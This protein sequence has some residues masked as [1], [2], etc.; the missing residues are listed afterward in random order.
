[1]MGRRTWPHPVVHDPCVCPATLRSAESLRRQADVAAA[2]AKATQ[3][4]SL[5]A[6]SSQT[7]P[8][9]ASRT[10]QPAPARGDV[11]PTGARTPVAGR[12]PRHLTPPRHISPPCSI[13]G[14]SSP[15]RHLTPSRL[16]GDSLRS[17]SP[18]LSPTICARE[19]F[20]KAV[21]KHQE[22]KPLTQSRGQ[23]P[24]NDYLAEAHE[25]RVSRPRTQSP[26]PT[27]LAPIRGPPA[28]PVTLSQ[29]TMAAHR[30]SWASAPC[31]YTPP[32]CPYTPPAT[33]PYTPPFPSSVKTSL[34]ELQSKSVA[35]ATKPVS[36]VFAKS[37]S[38]NCI[39]TKLTVTT[40]TVQPN[41]A[42]HRRAW[43]GQDCVVTLAAGD[44][45]EISRTESRQTVSVKLRPST[46]LS[47]VRRPRT[48]AARANQD[49]GNAS[50]TT[51]WG[52]SPGT[53]RSPSPKFIRSARGASSPSSPR[54][55][56]PYPASPRLTTPAPHHSP[57]TWRPKVVEPSKVPVEADQE[58]ACPRPSPAPAILDAEEGDPMP[59]GRQ[60]V[61][62]AAASMPV[63]PEEQSLEFTFDVTFLLPSGEEGKEF[64]EHLLAACS[65]LAPAHVTTTNV[66]AVDKLSE[67]ISALIPCAG[68]GT[69]L[70][71]LR[72]LG[73]ADAL[74]HV[75]LRARC[76]GT[77][78]GASLPQG[79]LPETTDKTS[80]RSTAL[81]YV[82]HSF[83]SME[84]KERQLGPICAVEASYKA[85]AGGFMPLRLVVALHDA[86]APANESD[87]PG[88]LGE[89]VLKE[90]RARR[91]LE[92]PGLAVNRG[93]TAGHRALVQHIAECLA[94]HFDTAHSEK[95]KKS[96]AE[97][98]ESFAEEATAT[99]QS[100]TSSSPRSA[101]G[102]SVLSNLP[103]GGLRRSSHRRDEECGEA[104]DASEDRR[105]GSAAGLL[106][107]V[108]VA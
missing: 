6:G 27:P 39:T 91:V 13:S 97:E 25:H 80:A 63:V 93:D 17:S 65:S 1:M 45:V 92:L 102:S 75:M 81:V 64:M 57:D 8:S 103:D 18:V 86:E 15:V 46:T 71:G 4:M 3:V 49:L 99:P 33:P 11:S 106:Q 40:D 83:R 100:S 23:S 70:V 37:A 21:N 87:K 42:V 22:K 61:R 12:G 52:Q 59:G 107:T 73:Q 90:L 50:S 38:T 66:N 95:K 34:T 41:E 105:H 89:E 28:P 94:A 79:G 26:T 53:T 108:L 10:V 35:S 68:G 84:D 43:W 47:E 96:A 56:S 60:R 58:P 2:A 44:S 24:S 48:A 54:T 5:S 104:A 32:V 88:P 85:A 36:K 78:A 62:R 14:H 55:S 51:G 19:R 7:A 74:K 31:S 20:D 67:P 29:K 69:A 16:S 82:V 30:P 101:P 77:D 9:R 72:Q 76:R 98:R